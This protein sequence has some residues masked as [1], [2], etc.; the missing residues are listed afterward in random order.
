MKSEHRHELKT[1]ELAEWL[2]N[3][4]QWAKENATTII[5]VSVFVVVIAGVYFWKVYEK[6]AIADK[7]KIE[8]TDIVSQVSQGKT[9]IIQAQAQAAR[10]LHRI[11]DGGGI[12]GGAHE[13]DVR[14]PALLEGE[15][16]RGELLDAHRGARTLVADPL[17]LA[18]GALQGTA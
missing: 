1:N 7:A 8:F 17:V 2:I 11:D 6:K 12:M 4:P 5:Y 13:V 14:A 3:F 9:Q 16:G 15:H 10:E 18:E